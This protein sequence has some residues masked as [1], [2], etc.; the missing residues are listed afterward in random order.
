MDILS[1]ESKI[2]ESADLLIAAGVKQSD[3]PNYMMPFFA[4]R[5]VESRLLRKRKAL[6]QENNIDETHIDDLMVFF[7]E[8][9][10]YNEVLI[11]NNVKLADIVKTEKTFDSDFNKYLNDFDQE[12]RHL[13]GY[14]AENNNEKFLNLD[15][16]ISELKGKKI[17][18]DFVSVWAQIDLEPFN[19]SEITTLEEHIKRRWADLSASTAG[20]QYTPDDIIALISDIVIDKA[21]FAEGQFVQI[22]D[23][24]CGGGNLLFGLEDR[25]KEHFNN[26]VYTA[27]NGMDLNSQLYALA[28]IESLFRTD[29]SIKYGNT[30]T[31][32]S[33]GDKKFDVIVANPPYGLTWK[34]FKKAIDN[35]QTGRFPYLPGISDSQMLFD[36][37]IAHYMK[38]DG[39]AVIVNNGS[40]L[41]SGDA[42]SG[43]SEIRKYLLDHDWVEALI[44]MPSNEFF[45]TGIYTYLWVLNKNKPAERKDKLILI[46]GSQ[47]FETLKKSKG[48]KR[49]TM[50]E[51][52]RAQIVEA[53]RNFKDSEISKVFD[54][55][56][57]YYN[58]FS[59]T[60]FD[61]DANGKAYCDFNEQ[62]Q[63]GN[64]KEAVYLK[65]PLNFTS[66]D[67]GEFYIDGSD[68]YLGDESICDN[69]SEYVK[70]E[71]Y[72]VL[73]STKL[74]VENNVLKY[75]FDT[76]CQSLIEDKVGFQT[77]LGNGKINFKLTYKKK[78]VKKKN[79]TEIVDGKKVKKEIEEVIPEHYTIAFFLES[80]TSNDYEIIPYSPD[81]ATNNSAIA[82]FMQKYVT[83]PW[84]FRQ[85]VVGTEINFNKV[86]YVPETLRPAAKILED[87][88]A[89]DIEL[90]QLENQFAL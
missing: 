4:L 79:I 51:N 15:G 73:C 21:H 18:F 36:L 76:N 24:T 66:F 46:N 33:F 48:D 78:T 43:E 6:M 27:T 64:I 16:I 31:D 19:N 72:P 23:P 52:H 90:K 50:N 80:S 17:F 68:I 5:L 35:D 47:L 60:L 53:L 12:T 82:A 22:Y 40:P 84:S 59:I 8:T 67:D 63:W 69:V 83:R 9:T 39:I 45:N 14:K 28:K 37:H 10:G 55:W 65:T 58:K 88:K 77:M 11:K 34:G 62:T 61:V 2:W 32:V 81:E 75:F 7:D 71:V 87:I 38:S 57:C 49:N 70:E 56:F 85:N 74:L 20:E 3:F 29:S 54:K 44:Q 13:L 1:Y 86:F 41:F 25:I 42:G 30:L 89:V 26:K